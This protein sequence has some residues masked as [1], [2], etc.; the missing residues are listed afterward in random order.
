MTKPSRFA[1]W[2]TAL[3]AAL[4][5]TGAHAA[6]SSFEYAHF[7]R[8]TVYQP[9]GPPASVALF[10]SGDGGWKLG[11]VDME[12]TLTGLGAMVVGID[13]RSYLASIAQSHG[14]CVSLAGDFENLSHAAQKQY[15]LARYHVPVV[16]GYS[17]GATLVYA[18]LA[19]APRGTLAGGL[20]LGFSPDLQVGAELCKG[21]DLHYS[22]GKKG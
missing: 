21:E 14:S 6:E 8:V 16:V 12:Q 10:V 17:S 2:M 13:I 9:E 5:L 1:R 19:Q 11:V 22:L 3:A 15:G 20:S 18:L 4:A 7:G